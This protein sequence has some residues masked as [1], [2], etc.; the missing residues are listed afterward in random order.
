MSRRALDEKQQATVDAAQVAVQSRDS[1]DFLIVA[2]TDAVPIFRVTIS[3]GASLRSDS[4]N[5]RT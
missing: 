5:R 1:S 4:Q 3:P 2:R